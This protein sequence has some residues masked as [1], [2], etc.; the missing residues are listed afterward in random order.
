MRRHGGLFRGNSL[1]RLIPRSVRIGEIR[2]D[3]KK[4]ILCKKC[5]IACPTHAIKVDKDNKKW[6]FYP[7]NCIKCFRCKNKCP[8]NAIKIV[9]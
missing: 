2:A 7:R 3:G 6:Y 5:E 8:K 4:C 9:P 1:F